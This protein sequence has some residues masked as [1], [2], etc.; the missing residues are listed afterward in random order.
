M[1]F[2]TLKKKKVNLLVNIVKIMSL[3]AYMK[4]ILECWRELTYAKY[5]GCLNNN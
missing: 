3:N 2:G 1:K 4:R 5:I